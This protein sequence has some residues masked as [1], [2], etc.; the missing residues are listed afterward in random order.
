[1][2]KLVGGSLLLGLCFL[3]PLIAAAKVL[4]SGTSGIINVPSAQVRMLGHFS[5]GGQWT[6]NGS[7][8]GGNL[9]V[10]PGLEAAYSRWHPKHGSDLNIVSGK[11]QFLPETLGTP[12][13]AVGVEDIGNKIDRSAYVVATKAGPWGLKGHV[14]YGTDRFKRG[15]V[16]LEKQFKVSGPD[17]NLDLELEYDG[18]DFN[19]GAALPLGK[20]LQ[21]EVG[22]RSGDLFAGV[23]WTF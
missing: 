19:Y 5:L 10:L 13:I 2:K 3:Q 6:E 12:A 1:M 7:F 18:Y 23:S 21:A 16:A 9:A 8:A 15:F 4:P 11:L 14:G 22:K 17:V 20:F